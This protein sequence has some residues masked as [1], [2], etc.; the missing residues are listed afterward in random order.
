[1]QFSDGIQEF[2]WEASRADLT[3]QSLNHRLRGHFLDRQSKKRGSKVYLKFLR[4]SSHLATM[5]RATVF[6]FAKVGGAVT[7]QD[8]I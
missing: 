2:I 1:M 7:E 4:S 5:I 3:W 6:P 8:G